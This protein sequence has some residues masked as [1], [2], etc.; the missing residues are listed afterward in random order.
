MILFILFILFIIMAAICK[1]L[2]DTIAF[3]GGGKLKGSFFDI[4]KQGKIIPFTKYRFDGFHVFNSLM[5]VCFILS[6]CFA[7]DLAWYYI[8]GIGGVLFNVT[9]NLFW[10]KIFN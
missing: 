1:A 8:L 9:F 10:N 2:V 6:A 7:P 5:I 3:H 4:N